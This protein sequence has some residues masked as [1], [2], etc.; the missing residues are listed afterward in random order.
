MQ[1]I[2]LL[3]FAP[4]IA[5]PACSTGDSGGGDDVSAT[6]GNA[7]CDPNETS[8]NFPADCTTT[9]DEWDQQLNSRVIDYSSAL[10]IASLRLTGMLPSMA[11]INAVA[12]AGD[13]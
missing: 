8:A 2:S 7:V 13:D 6:C 1:R 5:A 12:N 10:K 11:D 4:A 9:R 3:L